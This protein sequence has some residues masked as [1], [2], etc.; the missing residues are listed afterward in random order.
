M[1][2][3]QEEPTQ[4]KYKEQWMEILCLT[5]NRAVYAEYYKLL[6]ESPLYLRARKLCDWLLKECG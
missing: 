5:K 2:L 3:S 6:R 1:Y 4:V